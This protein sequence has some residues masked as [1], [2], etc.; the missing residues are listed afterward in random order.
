VAPPPSLPIDDILPDLLAVLRAKNQAVLQ[1]PPGAGKTTRVPL[2]MLNAGL[3]QGRILMLE[4]RRLATRAA[5]ERMA[6]SLG[7]E[8]GATVGYRMR[9]ESRAGK[10]TRIE[11]VTEGILTRMIQSDPDL[12]GIGAVI[13]DEFHERSLQG[14]LGLALALEIRGALRED[15]MLVVMSATLDAAP[16][17]GLMGDAPVIT[18][19]GRMFAVE[20]RWL[21]RPWSRPNQRGPRFENALADLVVQAVAETTGGVLVFLPGEGEIRRVE[22]L[23]KGRLGPECAVHPLF[24]AMP[25]KAQRAA[26]APATTGRKIVLATSIAETSLTIDGVQVVV[27]GG[28]ARRSR[29]DAGSGMSRL[30]TERVAKAEATQRQGR[31]GRL[32]EGNCYKLWTKGEEGGMA[33]FPPAEIEAADLAPLLL[34][35]AQWGV[36]DPADLPFLTSPNVGGVERARDLLQSLGALDQGGGITEHGR[37]MAALPLHPRLA[38]MVLKGGPDAPLLAAMLAERDVLGGAGPRAPADLDLRWQ[39]VRDVKKFTAERPFAVNRAVLA[40]IQAEAK[41]LRGKSAARLGLAEM[42]AL[43][44]PD[45]IGLRRKG[46]A[47]RYVLSGGKGAVFDEGEA[48]GANRL[49]VA[50][51]LDGDMREARIRQAVTFS[52]AGLRRLF[53]AAITRRETCHWSRR[54]RRVEAVKQEMFGALVL[55]ESKWTDCLE[56]KIAAAM[57]DGIRDLGI[58]ALPFGKPARLLIGRIEWLRVHGAEMPD[59]S[60]DGLLV[61]LEGWLLG[62]LGTCRKPDD[63]KGIDLNNAL[64]ARLSWEQREALDRLAPAAIT[65]PTGS[66]LAVDYSGAQ[67]SVSV[68]LQEMFGLAVHPVIG[69]DHVPLLIELLS[70]AGRGVQLTADLPGFWRDSYLDVRKDMRGRYPKHPWPENPL[71]AEATRRRKPRGT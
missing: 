51:D 9:G 15:L 67:P 18:S 3:V 45:R 34:E 7:E 13:F 56:D 63:L 44:Y 71:E 2:A 31:A 55:S 61:G 19:K 27:D 8:V 35:V 16:V 60:D 17:A 12:P 6:Q 52:E 33:A 1:A 30:V 25:F 20:S 47:P 42:V 24:G 11:V 38:H 48:L 40:R 36:I 29:F 54:E 43:A 57:C 4:P 5:A 66:R 21:A 28:R 22:G 41:R 37:E 58:G 65:A 68:R 23:L 69:P 59:F 70:P 62:F 10:Q 26:I 32:S 53:S 39:A 14:D 64:L 46:D 50:S 49:I